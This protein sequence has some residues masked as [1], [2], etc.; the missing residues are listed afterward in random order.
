MTDK[1]RGQRERECL[2]VGKRADIFIT[3]R[4]RAQPKKSESFTIR[5]TVSHLQRT[6][7]INVL[8][9]SWSFLV[10]TAYKIDLYSQSVSQSLKVNH[11]LKGFTGLLVG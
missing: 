3:L 1:C 11:F 7:Q 6:F 2:L 4:G 10:C 9:I 8:H 5:Y